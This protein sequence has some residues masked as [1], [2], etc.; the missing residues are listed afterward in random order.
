MQKGRYNF[1]GPLQCVANFYILFCISVTLELRLLFCVLWCLW[2]SSCVPPPFA[3]GLHHQNHH[4]IT[5]IVTVS[6]ESSRHHLNHHGITRIIV[7]LPESSWHHQ[8]HHGITRIIVTLPESS[9][10]HLNHLS[11]TRIVVTMPQ[12]LWYSQNHHG[13][14][15]HYGIPRNIVTLPESSEYHSNHPHS[16]QQ[17]KYKCII[18]SLHWLI[19]W[20]LQGYLLYGYGG[21]ELYEYS[22][23]KPLEGYFKWKL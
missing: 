15:S 9:Q 6:P 20:S 21:K 23:F 14:I 12:S 22:V 1:R 4:G 10:H 13:I 19:V 18:S 17:K 5:R 8:N 7:T 11:I 16:K 3:Q 2:W